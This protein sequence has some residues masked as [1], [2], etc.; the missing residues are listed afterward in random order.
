MPYLGAD[1]L[2]GAGVPEANVAGL[3]NCSR[4]TIYNL[5]TRYRNTGSTT[6]RPR[7]GKPR[8]TTPT[9]DRYIRIIYL[10]ERH[11]VKTI[12]GHHPVS[13]QTAIRRLR[14]HGIR[15]TPVLI[16]A[17]L[18]GANYVATILQPHVTPLSRTIQA[19]SYIRTTPQPIVPGRHKLTSQYYK[20]V[21]ST[22]GQQ[23]HPT[24]T[25]SNMF[26]KFSAVTS[27]R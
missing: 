22:P 9:Q 21:P 16:P 8:V 14:E 4:E 27:K 11:T 3:L 15:T 7:S 5:Q 12:S 23:S 25:R 17:A 19:A 13:T 10:R 18:N 26:G 20:S 1:E 6:G 2:I 24:R